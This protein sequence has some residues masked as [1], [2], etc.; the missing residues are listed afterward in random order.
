MHQRYAY[1]SSCTLIDLSVV[2]SVKEGRIFK[3]S[4]KIAQYSLE[5]VYDAFLHLKNASDPVELKAFVDMHFSE[6]GSELQDCIPVD[7]QREPKS[8]TFIKDMRY[9]LWAYDIHLKWKHLCRRVKDSVRKNEQLH[10][11]IPVPR[12]FIVP[13]GRF[14]EYYYWDSYWIIKGLLLSGMNITAR[15]MIENL[16]YMIDKF[17]FV[18][19]GGRIYYKNR[20]HPPMLAMAVHAYYLATYDS[21]FV[22]TL[23]PTIERELK[24]WDR[25]RSVTVRTK[26][27]AL[28]A[29]YQYRVEAGY[30]RPES[31]WEDVRTAAAQKTERDKAKLWSNIASACESG[32]DFSSRWSGRKQD[33]TLDSIRTSEIVPVDLNALICGNRHIL[34]KLFAVAGDDVNAMKYERQF[35]QATAA[36]EDAF[37]DS[38]HGVWHDINLA[39]QQRTTDYYAS[40]FFPLF[41]GCVRHKKDI[42][43]WDQPNSWPHLNHVLIEGLRSTD[44]PVA[45]QLAFKL[46]KKWLETNYI[47]YIR[48]GGKMF[49]KYNVFTCDTAGRGGEYD[50]QEGFGW[51]NGVVLDLLLTY[52]NVLEAPAVPM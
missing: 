23:L 19:N 30:P 50:V 33:F 15:H 31:Y 26:S 22:K 21:D 28:A 32:W 2:K 16:A 52:G 48:S 25:N 45:K 10:S 49:E 17:G 12:Q 34:S 18:P 7:W 41:T 13:G 27:G 4:N 3:Q 8:F 38:S 46:A 14:R 37:W 44:E 24:F 6:P 11:L 40:D 20:S 29:L 5:I 36:V 51:T 35:Q 42:G 43:S 1:M 9:R 47:V 39:V